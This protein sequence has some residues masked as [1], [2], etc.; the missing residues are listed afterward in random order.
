LGET[1]KKIPKVTW[2]SLNFKSASTWQPSLSNTSCKKEI[3]KANPNGIF[4]TLIL[5]DGQQKLVG[6]EKLCTCE[7]R[8]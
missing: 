7:V 3:K 8:P 5:F 4:K 2:T 1:L 6:G